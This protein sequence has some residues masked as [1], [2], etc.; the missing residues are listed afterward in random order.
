MTERFLA[1][2]TRNTLLAAALALVALPL[3]PGDGDAGWAY[4]D[5]FLL[6]LCFTLFGYYID[7]LL[8][9][10]PGIESGAGRLVRVAG[11]F[12]GGVWCYVAGRFV[13]S[14]LGRDTAALPAL[15]WGG[16][17]LVALELGLHA[18]MRARGEVR[19]EL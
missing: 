1:V 10:L 7:L 8:L 18:W 2:L 12:G 19:A 16:A 13:W 11:W 14:L 4:V 15:A 9:R 17:F 5:A 3:L 6:M